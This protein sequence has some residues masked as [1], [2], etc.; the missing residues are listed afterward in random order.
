MSLID[1]EDKGIALSVSGLKSIVSS[2]TIAMRPA[3][4]IKE[5]CI[6]IIKN[7]SNVWAKTIVN[8]Y[9]IT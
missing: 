6:G 9:P 8:D 7:V 2:L 3:L 1:P 4:A 5:M